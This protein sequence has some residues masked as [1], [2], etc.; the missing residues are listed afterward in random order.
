MRIR[1]YVTVSGS[2][3]EEASPAGRKIVVRGLAIWTFINDIQ[4]VRALGPRY[5]DIGALYRSVVCADQDAE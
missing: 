5:T 3:R 1:G 4:Y 2:Y